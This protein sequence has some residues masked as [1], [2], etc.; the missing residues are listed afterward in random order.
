MKYQNTKFQE[1]FGDSNRIKIIEFYLES[2]DIAFPIEAVVEEKN[3]G[4]SQTYEIINSMIKNNILI[5]D[6]IYNKKRFYKLNKK[7][8]TILELIKLFNKIIIP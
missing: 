1:L 8:E 2:G 6:K 4:K 5:E 3:I 7:N